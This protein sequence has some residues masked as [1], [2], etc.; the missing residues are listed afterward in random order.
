M[1]LHTRTWG[2]GERTAVLIHGMMSDSRTWHR[3]A[4]AIAGRGYRV[5]GVDLR[6]HGASGR[7][8]YSPQGWADDLVQ[9]LP[10]DADI[11]I[12]HS[13][14]AVALALAVDRLRPGRA[15]YADPAW[16]PDGRRAGMD[17]GRFKR[18]KQAT[19]EQIAEL[20]PRWTPEDVDVELA[21]LRD[22]DPD[23]ADGAAL[24]CGAEIAPRRPSVPSLVLFADEG[25]FSSA[26]TV[27]AMRQRGLDVRV[28]PG[29]GHTIHRDDFAAFLG[30]LEGW[31]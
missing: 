25:P 12:G 22:W 27:T 24:L 18:C 16:L 31:I 11:A 15:V 8:D 6:G 4:P 19:R 3:V 30:S 20:N 9:T 1:R 26:E 28:V 10:T 14:G 2:D 17:P 29:V 21:T 5:I 23:T 13:F 7:G